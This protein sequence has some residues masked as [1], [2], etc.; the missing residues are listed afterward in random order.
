[1]FVFW[2]VVIGYWFVEFRL[3][4][5]DQ[6]LVFVNSVNDD[7]EGLMKRQFFNLS[8]VGYFQFMLKSVEQGGNRGDLSYIKCLYGNRDQCSIFGGGIVGRKGFIGVG[9]DFN[10]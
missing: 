8:V 2:F 6:G 5:V 4:E 1:M 3:V 10:S 7:S 9:E